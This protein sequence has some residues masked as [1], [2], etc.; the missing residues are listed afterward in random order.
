MIAIIERGKL[1]AW[2]LVLALTMPVP[3]IAQTGG[4]PAA[5]TSGAA[6]EASEAAFTAEQLEQVAAPIA[7]YPDPLLAQ[8]LMA[9]TYPL[10]FVQ[11]HRVVK[12]NP[13]L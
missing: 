7:L 3:A 9:S 8:V 2:L 13:N 1:L 12:A 10:E 11:A 5:Q 4:A 6:P